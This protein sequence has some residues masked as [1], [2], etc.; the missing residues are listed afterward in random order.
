VK[1]TLEG[2]VRRALGR[3]DALTNQLYSWRY[4]PLYHSGALVVALL[5]VI[6]VTGTYLVFFYRIGAP[7]ASVARITEQVWLGRWV[8]G[9]HRFASDAAVVAAAIH[10]LRL[11]VQ[12]R[13]WGPRTLAWVSGVVLFIVML[14]CGWTGYVMVWDTQAQVLAREGARLLDVLPIFSEPISRG[15]V[16]ERAIPAA[17]FFLNLFL[18][19]ALPV[20]LGIVLW[21]HVS[22]VARPAL[23]PPRGLMWAAIGL[24]L[25]LSLAWPIGMAPPADL[26]RFPPTAP[27]DLFYAFFLPVT[28]RLTPW[29]AWALA[30]GAAAILLL[31]PWL[32]RPRPA[33]RPAPSWVDEHLCTGCEQCYL[34]C[35]YEAISMIARPDGRDTLV[36]HV[37]PALC[38]SCGICA[39]SC[40]PMGV[41][42]PDRTGRDQLSRV[43]AFVAER[44]PG[45]DDVVVI[46]CTRG[47]GG[48]GAAPEF[49]GAPVLPVS[50]A[51]SLHT[52]VIEYLVRMGAGG[53]LVVSCPPRDCWNREGPKWL[54][55]RLY[56]DREA[57]LQ[58]R[59]DRRRV[60]L[61]YAGAAEPGLVEQELREFQAAVAE[62]RRAV[63]EDVLEIGRECAPDAPEVAVP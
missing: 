63:R 51:G 55:Q 48:A 43:R 49:R 5:A 7:Y 2:V 4:N 18:H 26:L 33:A 27:Y 24:L 35:P 32:T 3:A 14:I 13:S 11:F 16:G 36:A 15:F 1:A 12:H 34:D 46:A 50:C 52:S 10:A 44:R 59:V 38:V 41:G 39:G 9:L 61:L 23:L 56:H 30:A 53:A 25:L 57:E 58:E 40:A 45:P 54:E 17:F 6:L 29:G 28:Q 37:N 20:G 42:P 31:V 21:L 62:L 47:A 8:R 60:R 22:R 19:V